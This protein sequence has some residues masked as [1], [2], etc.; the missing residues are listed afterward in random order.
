MTNAKKNTTVTFIQEIKL[1]MSV[2]F[3]SK[4]NFEIKEKMFYA[5]LLSLKALLCLAEL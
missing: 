5:E 4:F 2:P 3:Y 1:F